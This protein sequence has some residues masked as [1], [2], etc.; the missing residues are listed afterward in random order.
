MYF[1][2]SAV[3]IG[4]H[5]LIDYVASIVLYVTL[6]ILV[7]EYSCIVWRKLLEFSLFKLIIIIYNCIERI[8]NH[9]KPQFFVEANIFDGLLILYVVIFLNFIEW[10]FIGL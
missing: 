9:L 5:L 3:T 10:P 4:S 2:F 1:I 6:E 8:K 7:Q